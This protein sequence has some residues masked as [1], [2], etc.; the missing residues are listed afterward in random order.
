LRVETAATLLTGELM[1]LIDPL[2]RSFE[3]FVY[4]RVCALSALAP[5]DKSHATG[6]DGLAS[7][8]DPSDSAPRPG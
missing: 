3:R 1:S 7:R 5:A 4:E 8:L 2:A 6:R